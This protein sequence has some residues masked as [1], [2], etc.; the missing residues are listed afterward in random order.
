MKTN[1]LNKQGILTS[2]DR[3]ESLV[4]GLQHST[5]HTCLDLS[6]GVKIIPYGS[7][8][9]SLKQYSEDMASFISFW[10]TFVSRDLNGFS[11]FSHVKF[12]L[13]GELV[14]TE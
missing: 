1:I 13:V 6:Q 11:G 10:T 12:E 14:I 5:F 2:E 8:K 9:M 7:G 4:R 3:K